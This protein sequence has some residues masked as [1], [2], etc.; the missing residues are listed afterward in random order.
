MIDRASLLGKPLS[1]KVTQDDG[2][3]FDLAQPQGRPTAII[4]WSPD[5]FSGLSDF[6]SVARNVPPYL[7]IV[8]VAVGGGEAQR[9]WA[10]GA[11]PLPGISCYPATAAEKQVFSDAVKLKYAPGP[12]VYVLNPSGKV[13]AF[14]RLGEL[15]GLAAK[16]LK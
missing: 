1:A 4:V 11:F 13:A 14:G 8:Y 3:Q 5:R 2:G 15:P 6:S 7:Q 9:R 10:R 16:A 12:Y